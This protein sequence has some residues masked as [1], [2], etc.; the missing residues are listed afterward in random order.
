MVLRSLRA[1]QR[2]VVMFNVRPPVITK[3]SCT[4]ASWLDIFFVAWFAAEKE[5]RKQSTTKLPHMAALGD[6]MQTELDIHCYQEWYLENLQYKDR[7]LTLTI[8]ES[9]RASGKLNEP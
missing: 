6:Y 1:S 2:S 9:S 5:C 8:E 3:P 7:L 4:P